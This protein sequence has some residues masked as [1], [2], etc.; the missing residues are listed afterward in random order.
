MDKLKTRFAP[1]PTGL[2]HIGQARTAIFSYCLARQSGGEF[3]L[4]IEDTDRERH[5]EEAIPRIIEDLRWLG[6]D[7]NEGV[8]IGP[9]GLPIG[10]GPNGPYRQSERLAI[11]AEHIRRLV[12]AGLAYYCFETE[13]EEKVL[14]AAAEAA[15]V[16]FR[17]PRPAT[18]PTHADA[19]AARAAG[20]PVVVRFACP[21]QDVTIHDDAFGDVTMPA[22]EMDDFVLLKADGFP[23]YH[24]ANVIDDA[25]MGV[26]YIVRGQEFLGQ[27]WRHVLLRRAWGFAEPKGYCHLPLILNPDNSKMSKRDKH[28]L[29][30]AAAKDALAKGGLTRAGLASRAGA[31]EATTTAWLDGA[32][33]AIPLAKLEHLA[34]SLNVHLPEIDVADFRRSGYLPEAVINFVAL[35]GWNPGQDR[36]KFTL[37]ELT[38]MFSSERVSKTN[39]RFDRAKLLAFNTDDLAAADEPRRLAALKDFL[40]LNP[41]S[42]IPAGNDDLLRTLLRATPTL[43][44]L[45]DLPAKCN[46]LFEA[47]DAYDFDAAAVEKNLRKGNNA[48]FDVLT[49]LETLLASLPQEAWQI[50]PLHDA[51]ETF[52][53]TNALGMGKV[54][55]PLRV[56]VTG[57]TV[58]P[59][60]ADTLAILGK[61]KTLARIRRCLALR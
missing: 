31:E 41:A 48:G 59:P 33:A 4:R 27:T 47:D 3:V 60:I 45:A 51:V 52:A 6:L 20:R 58:S 13:A 49:Q 10:R 44:T 29:T 37:A 61:E 50:Q 8:D 43:R 38:E 26:N 28:R 9:D 32:D 42:T 22:A 25:L 12:D 11:Y 14:R 2:L 17:Y 30:R 21:A 40:R 18:F 19:D 57:T 55:Q 7:W 16:P 34:A 5:I 54:A 53:A 1:S 39:A 23:T 24:P 15:K 56:A 35:L 36:E 46:V